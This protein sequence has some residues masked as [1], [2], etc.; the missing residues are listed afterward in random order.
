MKK[1][2]AIIRPEKLEVIRQGLLDH[3]VS[4]MTIIDVLGMGGQQGYHEIYRGH[5]YKIEFLP[6]IKLEI[7]VNDDSLSACIDLIVREGRTGSIGD[8]KIFVSDIEQMISIRTGELGVP[9]SMK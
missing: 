7:I 9:P 6:K 3:G 1:I 5:E 2:E 8:G 4:G